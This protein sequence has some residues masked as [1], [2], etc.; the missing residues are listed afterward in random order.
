MHFT[1]SKRRSV[2]KC[3]N[4]SATALTI[5]I[6]FG[7]L[8]HHTIDLKLQIMSTITF[9]NTNTIFE[10]CVDCGATHVP[11]QPDAPTPDAAADA[12][13]VV[14]A[15]DQSAN[16]VNNLLPNSAVSPNI[17]MQ[18]MQAPADAPSSVPPRSDDG[19][20]NYDSSGSDSQGAA[21]SGGGQ[22]QADVSQLPDDL[23]RFNDP[24]SNKPIASGAALDSA[25][26]VPVDAADAAAPAQATAPTEA[27][28]PTAPPEEIA[29]Y[30]L[31]LADPDIQ[32]VIENFGGP[33][34]PASTKTG[35]EKSIVERY[36]PDLAARLN[37]LQTAQQEVQKQYFQELTTAAEA[38]GPNQP[39]SLCFIGENWVEASNSYNP[40]AVCVDSSGNQVSP[41]AVTMGKS[42]GMM[43]VVWNGDTKEYR[44]MDGSDGSSSRGAMGGTWKLDPVAFTNTWSQGDSALQKA[45]NTLYGDQALQA[46]RV[47][48][49][50]EGGYS[51]YLTLAGQDLFTTPPSDIDNTIHIRVQNHNETLVDPK[52]PPSM[53]QKDMVW[54]DPGFGWMTDPGNIK[55]GDDWF[56]KVAS[57]GFGAAAGFMAGGFGFGAIAQGAVSSAASQMASTDKINF[58]ALL[59]GAISS[60]LTSGILGSDVMQNAGLSGANASAIGR[61]AGQAGVSGVVQQL[62]GGKFLDGLKQ[63]ALSGLASEVS[64]Q[65]NTQINS[66]TNLSASE[67]SMMGL[68]S[69][70]SASA[71]R[72]LGNPDDPLAGF[73]GDFLSS[74]MQQ[75]PSEDPL[76]EFIAENQDEWEQ[77][78]AASVAGQGGA[79]SADQIDGDR[80][81]FSADYRNEMDRASDANKSLTVD[82][83]KQ[84]FSLDNLMTIPALEIQG[85]G[86]PELAAAMTNLQGEHDKLTGEWKPC[87]PDKA[88]ASL[89]IVAQA[90]G[91]NYEEISA[92]YQKY[93]Q[94]MADR[95]TAVYTEAGQQRTAYNELDTKNEHRVPLLSMNADSGVPDNSA[96]MGSSAQLRFGK[97]VG[98]ALGGLDPVFGALLS[99]TGGLIGP[100][101]KPVPDAVITMAGGTE[102]VTNH[103][104]AHDAAGYL[105][106]Y[107]KIGPGYQYVPGDSGLVFSN[108]N[109]LGGQVAGVNFFN[110]IRLYGTPTP[111]KTGDWPADS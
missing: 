14:P 89:A 28:A 108:K 73:A 74:L 65:L 39:G 110:N 2:A 76:G 106:N 107:H 23:Q 49:S 37:Q 36:G 95:E 93:L 1:P 86:D 17:A 10:P 70:A 32:E 91:I 87:D 12:A 33:L 11:A 75:A 68:L 59:K 81:P 69:R 24:I 48:N 56:S 34:E 92:G 98:D 67:R 63:G 105:L 4:F 42:S 82:N 58:G 54:F 101:N 22:P 53:Y 62:T 55:E 79:E 61:I 20:S 45:F 6:P 84:V 18:L 78:Y 64:T 7:R 9:P 8:S 41:P 50:G 77:R 19:T 46:T 3:L 94:I 88:Q 29:A 15:D 51:S 43:G 52:D 97:M 72:A 80:D 96:H 30:E 31:M 100:G 85:A 90:R 26:S 66:N 57:F 109:P 71:I 44:V 27:A 13:A 21:S 40:F 25:E 35:V 103:G 5:A 83:T 104:I 47:S 111:P 38:P 102:A 60:G 99:P 16:P